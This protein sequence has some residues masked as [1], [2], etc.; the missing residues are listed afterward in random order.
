MWLWQFLGYS[1]FL[2]HPSLFLRTISSYNIGFAKFST[3]YTLSGKGVP[4]SLPVR[5]GDPSLAGPR[6]RELRLSLTSQSQFLP[7]AWVCT[8][9]PQFGCKHGSLNSTPREYTCRGSL[10]QIG[11]ESGLLPAWGLNGPCIFQLNMW[12]RQCSLY[13]SQSFVSGQMKWSI[14]SCLTNVTRRPAARR[15]GGQSLFSAFLHLF[16]VFWRKCIDLFFPVNHSCAIVPFP[17]PFSALVSLVYKL[18]K[19]LTPCRVPAISGCSDH[20][21]PSRHSCWPWF[22]NI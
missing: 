9:T 1:Y 3:E 11:K 22:V 16:C 4:R 7:M 5:I 19:A 6:V 17:F 8:R 18:G 10:D 21:T 13:S 2:P 12:N 15:V 20:W 14:P